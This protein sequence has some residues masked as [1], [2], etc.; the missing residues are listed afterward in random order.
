[1]NPVSPHQLGDNIKGLFVLPYA[2]RDSLF[3][4]LDYTFWHFT[5]ADLSLNLNYRYQSD[6]YL[7]A[8]AGPAVPGREYYRQNAHGLFNA[9]VTLDMKLADNHN[10]QLAL[11]GRNIT[12]REYRAHLIGLGGG[13]ASQTP[14]S[15][16]GYTFSA[17]SW[18]EP[19]SYGAE[20]IFE[21]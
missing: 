8:P 16:L 14:I 2:P 19:P 10:L 9:R 3:A 18:A 4:S 7:S 21:Y 17:V 12:N 11:W 13:G 20:V 1:M 15:Q 6:T 5:N